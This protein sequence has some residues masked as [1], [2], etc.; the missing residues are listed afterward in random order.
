MPLKEIF[1]GKIDFRL[2][3]VPFL[4]IFIKINFENECLD[5]NLPKI[6]NDDYL[7]SFFNIGH[8]RIDG[9]IPFIPSYLKK[10]WLTCCY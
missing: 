1:V 2:Q 7:L 6:I 5:K 4:E 3:I 10:S 8:P 9:N